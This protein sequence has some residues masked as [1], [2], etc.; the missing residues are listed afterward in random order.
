MRKLIVIFSSICLLIIL[1]TFNI[2][3]FN[4]SLSFFKIDKIEVKNL[5]IL[6]ETKITNLFNDELFGSNLLILD[7]KK[8][9]KISQTNKLIDYIE[10]R[11]IYPSK[12]QIIIYEKETIAIINNK[13]KKFYLTN[14][15]EEIKYFKNTILD[16]LPNIFGEQNNF[17]EI[18]NTLI[19]IN[20]PTSEIKSFYH[21]EIG[22]WDIIL[23]NNKIIKLP[24]KNFNISLKNYMGL[25]KQINSENYK[26]FDYRIK[27]QLIL[28]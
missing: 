10:F 4:T 3:N 5:K 2:E 25:D 20:F 26:I 14:E 17:L 9:D 8:I 7:E 13:Q 12:L 1:S 11:K 16:E 27:N 24:V 19:E 28:N 23:K 22:R 21:F 18:Y 15:G 6:N